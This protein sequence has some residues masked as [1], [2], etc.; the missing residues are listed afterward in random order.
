DG[1]K[2]LVR[3][4]VSGLD[5]PAA[6]A[7]I[8]GRHGELI[9]TAGLLR[10]GEGLTLQGEVWV[11]LSE[12]TSY[13]VDLEVGRQRVARQTVRLVPPRRCSRRSATPRSAGRRCS[14]TCS[15]GCSTTRPPRACCCP[16]PGSRKTA[17]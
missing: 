3:I 4:A 1:R 10:L 13:R 14:P 15:P 11:P 12:P 8:I 6:R 9:G 7:Q 2:N 16:R 17:G 5:A